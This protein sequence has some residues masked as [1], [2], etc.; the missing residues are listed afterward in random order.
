MAGS[1]TLIVFLLFQGG[2]SSVGPLCYLCIVF[3][4][5]SCLFIAALW[6]PAWKGLAPWLFCV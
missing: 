1:I 4:M 3:V 2:A 5:L 6:S